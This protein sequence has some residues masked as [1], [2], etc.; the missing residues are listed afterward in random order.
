MLSHSGQQFD[1]AP[2]L[3]PI[4]VRSDLERE[5]ARGPTRR[6]QA[7]EHVFI[8][9]DPRSSLYRLDSGAVCLYQILLSGRRR[10]TGFAFAGDIFGMG[11]LSQHA[12]SAQTLRRTRLHSIPTTTLSRLAFN[13]PHF[14]MTL[15]EAACRELAGTQQTLLTIK[16][17]AL[18]RLAIFLLFSMQRNRR[19]GEDP[20]TIVLPMTRADIGDF[21]GLTIETVSRMFT[22]LQAE[23][24]IEIKRRG[25]IHVLDIDKLRTLGAPEQTAGN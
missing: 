9:G 2:L 1:Y 14:G 10:V 12:L 19:N 6:L 21:L 5:I 25:P 15:Y 3:K 13:D 22:K 4:D 24:I 17:P 20:E 16:R 8:A 23:H 18:E 11:A 7:K